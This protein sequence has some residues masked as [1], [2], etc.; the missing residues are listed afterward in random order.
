[1][2]NSKSK[3]T[4]ILIVIL[5]GLLILAYKTMFV[6]DTSD[7]SFEENIAASARVE[8]ILSQIES[9]SFDTSIVESENF[10]SLKSIE[11]PLPALPVG[12]K[13]PFSS[14]FGPN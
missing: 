2:K 8:S 10:N 6:S 12:K 13:N 11:I 4:G 9:I 7:L 1:M 5:L 3:H 14:N